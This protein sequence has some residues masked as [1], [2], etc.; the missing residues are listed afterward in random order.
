MKALI[1]EGY[2]AVFVASGAHAGRPLGIEGEDLAAVVDSLLFLRERALGQEVACG[3]R[4]AVIGGGNA[5]IDAAR[6]ALR[7]GAASVSI[8][9][10]R[11]REEMPAYEEEIE[12]ALEEGVELHELVAPKRILGKNGKV[13]GIE[14][15]R[16]RLGDTDESGRRRPVAIEGSE[17]IVDCD[18][19]IPAIGQRPS[20]E[21]ADGAVVLNPRGGIEADPVTG[22]TS[23]AGVFAGGD[24]ISGGATVID[25]IGA[26][27]KAAVAIDR[28]L[29]RSGLLPAN[30]GSSLRRPSEEELDKIIPRVQE[31]ALSLAE[32]KS[33]FA[34]VVCGLTPG[35]ACQEAGRC[36]RCDLERAE[37]MEASK[38]S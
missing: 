4:V 24:C 33:N 9:Y 21:A 36:L 28:L 14:M 8:L 1:A 20:L 12:A 11:S 29:G 18:M 26:G 38:G 22:K 31:P 30:V 5:A 10:R 15:I 13:S 23:A 34:E 32:R 19:V 27:Q 25:A 16:M 6:S 35:A 37:S 2:K 17:F 7:L 3:K